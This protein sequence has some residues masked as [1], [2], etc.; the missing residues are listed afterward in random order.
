MI[1]SCLMIVIMA[2]V[3]VVIGCSGEAKL[4]GTVPATGTV[5]QKG[6][7]LAGATVTFGPA[8]QSGARA[9]SGK[10]DA[11]GQFTLTTL[12]ANDGAMPGDYEVTVTKREAVGKAYTPEEANKYYS[13]HHKSP[14]APEFKHALP[15]KYAKGAT[16]GLK[17]TV[18]SSGKNEFSFDIE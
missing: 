8:G 18:K 15:E 17:A 5:K 2:A 4:A 6:A 14:P 1:R 9:A 7:P 13:E 10:T 12:K 3:V 16:S 11:S